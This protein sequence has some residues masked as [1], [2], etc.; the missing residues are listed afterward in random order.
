M[1]PHSQQLS[2]CP[3]PEPED[4]SQSYLSMVQFN[5]KHRPMSWSSKSSLSFWLSQPITYTRS[6]SPHSSHP[7]WI[8]HSNYTWQRVQIT[9]LFVMQLSPPSHSFI[10]P[11]P[12]IL[13]S[14]WYKGV[15]IISETGAAICTTVV[16]AWCNGMIAPAYLGS[17]CTK[18]QA[19]EWTCWLFKTLYLESCIWPDAISRGSDKGTASNFVKISEKVRR[20]PWQWLD[21]RSGKKAATIHGNS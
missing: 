1:E 10:P 18:F 19:A 13:L 3:Y 20:R 5:I 12:N 4:K 8:N 7:P 9:K 11:R 6:S 16:V 2:S 14:S 15:S 21:K 17:Q